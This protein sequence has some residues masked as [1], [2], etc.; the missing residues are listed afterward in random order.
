MNITKGETIS[1]LAKWNNSDW[2]EFHSI[3]EKIPQISWNTIAATEKL[4]Y[5]KAIRISQT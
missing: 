2:V 4:I 1:L 5:D 3:Y